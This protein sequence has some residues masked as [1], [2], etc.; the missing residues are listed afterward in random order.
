MPTICFFRGIKIFINW[1]DHYPP[2]FH[3]V[4]GGMEMS[5]LIESAEP[6]A[7]E[8][9]PNQRKMVLA[10]AVLHREELLDDWALAERNQALFP[11]DPLR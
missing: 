2:H 8:L 7:G 10:W 4:Y 6:M 1:D 3:A 5:V 9:P 11:I